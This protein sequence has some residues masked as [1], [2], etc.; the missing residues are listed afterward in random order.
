MPNIFFKNESSFLGKLEAWARLMWE[1]SFVRFL[2]V[3]AFNTVNGILVTYLLRFIFDIVIGYSPK[4]DISL[5]IVSVQLDLPGLIMFIAL[6]PVAY[7]TQAIW[8]FRA[9]WSWS[10]LAVYPLSSIPNFIMQQGFIFLFEVALG[11]SPYISYALAGIL[12]IPIMFFIIR[13][14]VK[15]KTVVQK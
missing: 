4:W 3:G 13:F 15:S 9:K 12:P 11:W 6:L 10:R 5:W 8:A 7:T 2:F 14:L 1:K